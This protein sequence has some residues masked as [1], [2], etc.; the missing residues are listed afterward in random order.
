[1]EHQT[2]SKDPNQHSFENGS[3]KNQISQIQRRTNMTKFWFRLQSGQQSCIFHSLFC[4]GLQRYLRGVSSC[5]R[6]SLTCSFQNLKH[7]SVL[8]GCY[9][10]QFKCV[11]VTPQGTQVSFW[12]TL[13]TLDGEKES[14][15]P[16]TWVNIKTKK[17]SAVETVGRWQTNR[18]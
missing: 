1:M 11:R 17:M 10:G 14:K 12:P 9:S 18:Q 4:P 16:T 15:V 7:S 5:S 3:L 2:V 13:E 8:S 6:L